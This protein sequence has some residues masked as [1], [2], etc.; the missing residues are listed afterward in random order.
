M[1]ILIVARFEMERKGQGVL[2]ES[3]PRDDPFSNEFNADGTSQDRPIHEPSF[4]LLLW[5]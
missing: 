4:E 1:Q 5:R 3:L 2:T